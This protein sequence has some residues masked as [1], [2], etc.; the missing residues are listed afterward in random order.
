LASGRSSKNHQHEQQ[1]QQTKEKKLF[2]RFEF[3]TIGASLMMA[4]TLSEMI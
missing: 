2:Q 4:V 1:Q 3:K